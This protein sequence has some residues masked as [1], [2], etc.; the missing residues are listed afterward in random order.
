M[1]GLKIVS[2]GS[3]LPARVVT[4]DD[5]SKIVDT[6]DEWISSRTGIKQ[7]HYCADDTAISMAVSSGA[8]AIERSGVCVDEIGALI[9]TTFQSEYCTPSVASIVHKQL[10]LS[11]NIPAFDLNAACSGFVYALHVARGLL[12]Q[13]PK[14]YALIIASETLSKVTDF[15]D[16]ATCVLFGDASGAALVKL[17]K[18][19][20]YHCILGNDGNREVLYCGGPSNDDRYIRMDGKEVFRFAVEAIPECVNALLE[21]SKLTIDDINYIVCHQA[22]KRILDSAIKRLK[23]DDGKFYVNLDKYGNTSSASIPVA[24]DEMNT[25]GLL[26]K[27]MK[28]ICAGFGAGLTK[29]GVLLEW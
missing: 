29:A 25:A 23:A 22:N 2:T 27:G 26:K 3:Y 17:E 11:P 21:E 13:S 15:T 14:P 9:V 8:A 18:D 28:I 5:M 19:S 6:S 24:L 16:R 7:R 12:L 4:N 10:G 20:I 1:D